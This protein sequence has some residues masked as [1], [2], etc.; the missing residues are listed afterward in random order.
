MDTKSLPFDV[1]VIDLTGLTVIP[2]I[3]DPH[4]HATGGGGE[5][6]PASRTPEAKLEQ[7][8]E[9]GITCLVGVLGKW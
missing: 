1:N 7:L 4:V 6:G 3:V 9:A 5:K 8:I 2:G